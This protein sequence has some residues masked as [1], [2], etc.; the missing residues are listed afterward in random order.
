MIKQFSDFS[1]LFRKGYI[2]ILAFSLF[3]GLLF[4]FRLF[5]NADS[6]FTS[7]MRISLIQNVSIVSQLSVLLLPFL[8][9][10]FACCACTAWTVLPISFIKGLCFGFSQAAIF[11]SFSS[12]SWMVYL[13]LMFSNIMTLPILVFFWIRCLSKAQHMMLHF[14]IS[15]LSVLLIIA[16]DHYYIIPYIT[17]LFI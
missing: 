15:T 10:A 9:S 17:S 12:A 2:P 11:S 1:S 3:A 6:S 7:L 4:G 8:F 16:I 14:F 5:E 13:F